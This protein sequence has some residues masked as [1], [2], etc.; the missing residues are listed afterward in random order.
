VSLHVP[1]GSEFTVPFLDQKEDAPAVAAG[2]AFQIE[3]W[4]AAELQRQLE[5]GPSNLVVEV[6]VRRVGAAAARRVPR[7]AG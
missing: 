4:C 3:E 5:F 6:R 1:G 7:R 2:V